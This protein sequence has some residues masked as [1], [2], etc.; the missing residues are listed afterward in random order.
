MN[1]F[2]LVMF[3]IHNRIASFSLS[4]PSVALARTLDGAFRLK[5]PASLLN[6]EKYCL[7]V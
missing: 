3:V 5:F 7:V 4:Q 2:L 6:G 1:I